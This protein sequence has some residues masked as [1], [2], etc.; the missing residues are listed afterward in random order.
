MLA[1]FVVTIVIF[2]LV[3][4]GMGVRVLIQGRPMSG[5]CGSDPVVIEGEKLSCVGCPE[6]KKKECDLSTETAV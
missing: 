1:T 5:G 4:I 3:F 2:G 6:E